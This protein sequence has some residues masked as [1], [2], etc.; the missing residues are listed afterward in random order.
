MGFLEDRL[1][2]LDGDFK[3][4]KAR[5]QKD[6]NWLPDDGD[7]QMIVERF[8]TFEKKSDHSLFL[9]VFL[10]IA[11][12]REYDGQ[13]VEKVWPLD[14]PERMDWLKGDLKTM[15]VPV[16]DEDFSF[17]DLLKHLEAVLDVPLDC[18]VVTS[19]RRKPDSDEY[20]RNL[21]INGRL[22]APLRR[23]D[24]VR[25]GASDIPNDLPPAETPAQ[26]QAARAAEQFG[27]DVPDF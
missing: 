2:A 27:D 10:K 4:A 20:Y 14:D 26:R 17:G 24:V 13:T 7:Y 8:D 6:G 15:G 19:N 18:R 3:N 16:D 22:G 9:K 25:T 11:N 5:E 1:A 12:D 23:E 21:Y